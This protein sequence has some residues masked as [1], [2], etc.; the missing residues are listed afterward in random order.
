VPIYEYECSACGHRCELLIRPTPAPTAAAEPTCPSCGKAEL[1]RQLSMFAVSSEATRD[2]HLQ[3]ARRASM[4]EVKEKQVA[5][6][7]AIKHAHDDHH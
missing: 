6:A 3:S 1:V 7:E 2:A 5:E 4:K